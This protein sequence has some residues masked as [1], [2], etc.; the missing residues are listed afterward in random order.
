MIDVVIRNKSEVSLENL[1]EASVVI[2]GGPQEMFTTPEFEAIK[3]YIS[4]G[5]NVLMM[6]GEGG[7]ANLTN[8]NYLLEEYG[9][10]VN[11]DAVVRTVY[12]KSSQTYNRYLHPKEVLITT[13]VLNREIYKQ[14][15]RQGEPHSSDTLPFVYPYGATL[16]VQKPAVPI[17]SSG[18]DG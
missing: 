10:S 1:R 2:F 3:T 17:L 13:G 18:R 6:L 4:E 9:I 5:G 7:E 12:H 8:V 14:P 16:N 11:N 15:G